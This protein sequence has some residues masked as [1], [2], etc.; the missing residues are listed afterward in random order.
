MCLAQV[1]R[2][3][4]SNRSA[5]DLLYHDVNFDCLQWLKIGISQNQ[6]LD[7]ARLEIY[8][9]A[10]IASTSFGIQYHSIAK[11]RVSDALSQLEIGVGFVKSG[12]GGW[13]TGLET[14]APRRTS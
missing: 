4:G 6:P 8:L 9:H 14:W 2:D 3:A 5:F 13:Y 7:S 1:N 12:R 11:L 10:R